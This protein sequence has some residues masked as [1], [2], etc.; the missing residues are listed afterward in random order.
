[1]NGESWDIFF[2]TVLCECINKR[3]TTYP[4][5]LSLSTSKDRKEE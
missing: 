3:E 1:M 4:C 2:G 5:R